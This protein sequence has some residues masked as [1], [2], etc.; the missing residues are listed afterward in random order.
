MINQVVSV[1]ISLMMSV[2]MTGCSTDLLEKD[3]NV[4]NSK[5]VVSQMQTNFSE[6]EFMLEDNTVEK[7]QI[8]ING[9]TFTA[10]MENNEAANNFISM[11]PMT[12]DM[13]DL[14]R[15]EK[16]YYLSNSLPTDT[17]VPDKINEGDL[18]LYGSDCIV[19][20]YDNFSTS[21]RYTPLGKID[22]PKGLKDIIGTG[23]IEITFKI[24][25]G[26]IV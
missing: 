26:I 6:D 15:N 18:M 11:L 7:I 21:Y 9:K 19:L 25:R 13:Q 4:N 23:N 2:S 16:Y 3:D 17:F 8:I 10:T 14:N 22:D 1:L 20:F 5:E 24:E 12:L